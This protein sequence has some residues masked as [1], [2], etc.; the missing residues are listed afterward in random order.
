[1]GFVPKYSHFSGDVLKFPYSIYSRMTIYRYIPTWPTEVKALQEQCE[2][3]QDFVEGNKAQR[4]GVS[5]GSAE[6]YPLVMTN[7]AMFNGIS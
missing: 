7:I 1:M 2:E 3:M 5:S 4:D 6:R